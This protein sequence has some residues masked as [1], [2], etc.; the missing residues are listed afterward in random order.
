VCD[1]YEKVNRYLIV[2]VSVFS[3]FN[4]RLG[5]VVVVKQPEEVNGKKSDSCQSH[6]VFTG[7]SQPIN[8]VGLVDTV[9][10]Q[11]SPSHATCS[12]R[13]CFKVVDDQLHPS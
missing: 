4:Q 12:S 13:P 3:L 9:V 5:S 7:R 6:S 10:L 11:G 8:S 1:N 2:K